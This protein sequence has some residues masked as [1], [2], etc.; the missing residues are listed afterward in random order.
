MLFKTD[1]YGEIHSNE[2]R[3]R[4]EELILTAHKKYP[5]QY[6]LTEEIGKEI[7]LND[8]DKIIGINNKLYSISPRSYELAIKLKIPVIG[9]DTW[10][11]EVYSKD[12]KD[13][14][15]MAIDF[16]TSFFL[17]ESRMV[18]VISEYSKVGSCAVIVGDSHLRT[19][20]TKELGGISLLQEAFGNTKG[21]NIFRSPV[22]EIQ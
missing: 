16:S 19:I 8:K 17:R 15:G 3:L 1:I 4:V 10:D 21:F 14:N 5:Y 20:K 6:L 22:G 11:D 13:K 18:S 7:A 12:K 2:D 9:I